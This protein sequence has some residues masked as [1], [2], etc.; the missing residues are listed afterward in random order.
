M[1]SDCMAEAR[2][3]VFTYAEEEILGWHIFKFTSVCQSCQIQ[4]EHHSR[5]TNVIYAA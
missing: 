3:C 4:T 1:W 5:P 2:L